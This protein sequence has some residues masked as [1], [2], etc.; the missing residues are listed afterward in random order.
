MSPFPGAY[1]YIDGKMIKL[2]HSRV[3]DQNDKAS[4]LPGTIL[5][6]RDKTLVI[7]C[8][9]DSILVEE[10]QIEGKRRMKIAE[11]IRGHKLEIGTQLK[12]DKV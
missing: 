4:Y 2:F 1:S 12:S 8:L 3:A 7:K 6:I 10:I 5:D 9:N 11:Y